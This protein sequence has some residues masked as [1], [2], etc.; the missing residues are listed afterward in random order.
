MLAFV[1]IA[2]NS[3]GDFLRFDPIL[4]RTDL[5]YLNEGRN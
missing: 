1:H 5:L 2:Q 3:A 4:A